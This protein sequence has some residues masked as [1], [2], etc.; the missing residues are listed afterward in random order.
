MLPAEIFFWGF[1]F[2]NSSLRDVFLSSLALK[3]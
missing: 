1:L 2:L 3:G